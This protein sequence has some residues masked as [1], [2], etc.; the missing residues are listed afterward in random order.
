MN[1]I[2]ETIAGVGTEPK[3]LRRHLGDVDHHRDAAAR[4]HVHRRA[5]AGDV[6]EQRLDRSRQRDRVL[7]DAGAQR[8]AGAG[9]VEHRAERRLAV[10]A[11]AIDD[12]AHRRR[13]LGRA[14]HEVVVED[15]PGGVLA[16]RRDHEQAQA[17]PRA[18]L[19]IPRLDDRERL[20]DVGAA[21]AGAGIGDLEVAARRRLPAAHLDA[22]RRHVEEL[23]GLV[24]GQHAGDVVVDDDDLVDVAEPLL[25]EDA[26]RRRAAADAHA[27]L[28]DAVDDRRLVGLDDD[29]RAAVDLQ[30][31]RLLV[32]E[33]HHHL[34]G[35]APFLLRAAGEVVDAA[36][37]EE[38]RAVLD[39]ADVADRLAAVAHRR[40]L[41]AEVAVGVDLHLEAA[42]AE[43]AFGDDGDEVDALVL[44]GDDERR[45]LVVG[46]GRPRADAGDEHRRVGVR[47]SSSEPSQPSPRAACHSTRSTPGLA[48][49]CSV[50][51]RV[52]TPSTLP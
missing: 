23:A 45:R 10:L 6:D 39:R 5:A 38:L 2:G 32:A 50:S 35:D 14:R 34:A 17:G 4:P 24:L 28:L 33:R 9:D 15:E 22:G 43:D 52:S 47:A 16:G 30:L 1:S 21:P 26:D 51:S 8:P 46:I 12:A 41:G 20:G 37:G 36:E 40:L 48:T 49:R 7:G 11:D 25:R 42:V 3:L 27:L 44:R 29:A 18:V 31:D 19:R 13:H